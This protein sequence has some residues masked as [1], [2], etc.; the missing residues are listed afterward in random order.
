[1]IDVE[2][3]LKEFIISYAIFILFC[4]WISIFIR[5]FLDF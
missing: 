3:I 5:L 4:R 2:N 1:M